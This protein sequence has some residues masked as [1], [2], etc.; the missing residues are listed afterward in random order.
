[1]IT[2][3]ELRSLLLDCLRLWEVPGAV[4]ADD[5]GLRLGACVVRR[6]EAPMRWIVQTPARTRAAP[7]VVALLSLL[8]REVGATGG[9]GLRVGY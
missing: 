3:A 6:G 2:D 5:G 7:S 8:R 4:T 1:V 9:P